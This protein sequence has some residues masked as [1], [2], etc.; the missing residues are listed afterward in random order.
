M[1]G[2][3][4][5]SLESDRVE[6]QAIVSTATSLRV[7]GTSNRF[8]D[9]QVCW[10]QKHAPSVA[11]SQTWWPHWRRALTHKTPFGHR[12]HR[13]WQGSRS[14]RLVPSEK[15]DLPALRRGSR[16]GHQISIIRPANP[17]LSVTVCSR[18]GILRSVGSIPWHDMCSF[19]YGSFNNSFKATGWTSDKLWI[20][21]RQWQQI[22]LPSVGHTDSRDHPAGP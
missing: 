17:L 5:D 9:R 1:G 20:D 3:G 7:L 16:V 21:C 19:I 15:K 4:L 2:C 22:W 6:R 18:N 8:R 11:G 12:V 10:Q 14:D 13:V